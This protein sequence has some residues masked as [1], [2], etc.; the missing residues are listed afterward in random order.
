[1]CSEVFKRSFLNKIRFH[2]HM[3]VREVKDGKKPVYLSQDLFERINNRVAHSD[4]FTSIE[5]YVEYILDQVIDLL[6]DQFP[7]QV[8][9]ES[10]KDHLSI[11]EEEEE[12]IKKRLESLGYM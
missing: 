5:N 2:L 9:G 1:M 7:Y 11:H 4:E 8:E 3:A 6:E 12:K 10:S